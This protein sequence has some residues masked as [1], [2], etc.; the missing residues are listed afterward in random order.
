[1]NETQSEQPAQNLTEESS[2]AKFGIGARLIAAFSVVSFLTVIVSTMSWVSINNLTAAQNDL[3]EDNVPAITHAL[4]LSNTVTALT[5]AAPPIK[6]DKYDRRK[7]C[8]YF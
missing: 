4:N 6:R 2:Q 8:K 3:I 1:M 5:A 7:R